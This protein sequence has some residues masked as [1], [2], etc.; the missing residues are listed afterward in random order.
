M[1]QAV[2]RAAAV[3]TIHYERRRPEDTTPYQL[4]REHLE[5]FLLQVEARTGATP[6][7]SPESR[8]DSLKS[9]RC[10]VAGMRRPCVL[11]QR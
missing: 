2:Q 9:R 1:S 6:T 8:C 10:A 5:T 11:G 3:A 4:V 7:S